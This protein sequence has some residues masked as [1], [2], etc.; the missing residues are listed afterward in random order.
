MPRQI[1]LTEARDHLPALIRDAESGETIQLTRRG[2]PVAV[3]LSTAEYA[4]L[5]QGN[6]ETGFFESLMA[7][8]ERHRLDEQHPEPDEF[9]D[10]RDPAPGRPMDL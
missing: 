7:F 10:L 6:Q 9:D 1:P 2:Q 5:R 3:L 4:R 8:R